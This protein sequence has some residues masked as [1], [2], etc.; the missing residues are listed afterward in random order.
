MSTSPDPRDNSVFSSIVLRVPREQKGRLVR[1]SRARRMTLAGWIL[2]H[3]EQAAAAEAKAQPPAPLSPLPSKILTALQRLT[4]EREPHP[5][6]GFTLDDITWQMRA[7]FTPQD[8][9]E[10]ALDALTDAGL[11]RYAGEAA[12]A[13]CYA[14]QNTP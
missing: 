7:A 1:A 13:A 2:E 11:I 14:V 10:C 5:C 3:L 4:K 8:D 9:L 12:E 6:G